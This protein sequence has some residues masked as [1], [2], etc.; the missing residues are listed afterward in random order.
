MNTDSSPIGVFDSG[1]GGLTVLRALRNQLPGES[2]LYLGDTARLPY[3]TK[4]S[5][6]VQRYALQAARILVDRG[7]KA[8]V[9]ACNT[10]SAVALA[11]LQQQFAPLPVLG[12]V[13][14]GAQVAAATCRGRILVLATESTV[15][16]GA[17]QRRLLAL[18]P[19]LRV[20]ARPCPLLVALAEEGRHQGP[21]VTLALQQ[22]LQGY[23]DLRLSGERGSASGSFDT[24]LLGCT[25][26][27]VFR[28]ALREVLDETENPGVALVDSAETTARALADQLSSGNLAA[29]SADIEP[30]LALMATDGID[31]FRRVGGYF[32]G[33][34]LSAV[35]LVDL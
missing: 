25:H 11:S 29:A 6:T 9:V 24:L 14:P 1:M 19:D 13:E 28:D 23:A 18:R 15:N 30:T 20:F 21:L 5:T 3:G 12:V 17:Y 32:L 16:G 33:E 34:P 4:S 10:A 35:E 22:Y 31:R 7:V 27:P 8:L 2:F 26:F